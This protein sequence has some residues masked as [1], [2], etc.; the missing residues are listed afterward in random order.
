MGKIDTIIT[1]GAVGVA[2]VI[3]YSILKGLQG[4]GISLNPVDW[5][6]QLG[7]DIQALTGGTGMTQAQ[8]DTAVHYDRNEALTLG[9]KGSFPNGDIFYT[10]NGVQTPT[11]EA[12][13]AAHPEYR[14]DTPPKNNS[15]PVENSPYS[16]AQVVSNYNSSVSVGMPKAPL[17]YPNTAQQLASIQAGLSSGTKIKVGGS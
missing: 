1:L 17:V 2:G 9:T 13:L 14:K 11:D 10:L 3:A 12:W 6:T 7:K 8:A 4:T 5:G 16:A 15:V